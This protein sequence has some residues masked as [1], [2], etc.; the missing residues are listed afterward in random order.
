KHPDWRIHRDDRG[1]ILKV[2]A[3]EEDLGTRSGCNVGPWGDYLID[4]CAELAADF[5]LDG[6]S[7]DGNYQPAICYCSACKKAYRAGA[8]RA[9]S[10]GAAYLRAVAGDRPCASERYLMSRGN[11]YGTDSFPHHERLTRTL[12]ALTHGNAAAH[13]VGWPGHREST[14]DVF[15]EVEARE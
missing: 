14:R 10:C 4:L 1:S 6:F 7:F 5:G 8:G 9:P 3:D 11:P 13:S 12:L 15:R 2:K